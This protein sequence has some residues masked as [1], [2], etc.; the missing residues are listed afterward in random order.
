MRGY[1]R[2]EPCLV[3]RAHGQLGVERP[4]RVEPRDLGAEQLDVGRAGH[5]P[6]DRVEQLLHPA[7]ALGDHRDTDRGPLPL[8]LVVDLGDRDA[9]PVAQPV[10]DRADRR[11][12]RLQRPALRHVEV[13]GHGGGVHRSIVAARAAGAPVGNRP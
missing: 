10:D 4:V 8:V 2:G 6:L 7:V 5:E 13:E 3:T 1:L 12:L 11:P 9:E